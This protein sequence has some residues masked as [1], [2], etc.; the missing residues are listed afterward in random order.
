[1]SWDSAVERFEGVRDCVEFAT[2]MVSFLET[3]RT[4]WSA[5]IEADTSMFDL[6]FNAKENPNVEL[7]VERLLPASRDSKF[8][9]ELREFVPRRSLAEV[10]GVRIVAGERC[11][12]VRCIEV[13][14]SYLIQLQDR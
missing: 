12:P 4:R 3:L 13:A 9:F 8:R 1:M 7:R 11:S 6:V 5:T 2:Q 14:E 10:G